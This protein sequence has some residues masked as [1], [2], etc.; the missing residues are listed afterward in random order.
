MACTNTKTFT[1]LWTIFWGPTKCRRRVVCLY[2]RHRPR[3]L[4]SIAYKQNDDWIPTSATMFFVVKLSLYMLRPMMA[5][6]RGDQHLKG[7]V[8]FR[9]WPLLAKTCKGLILLLK[10][11]LHL[12]EF[13]PNFSYKSCMYF[14]IVMHHT[15]FK[16]KSLDWVPWTNISC[17]PWPL[18]YMFWTSV[19]SVPL[20]TWSRR[21]FQT[22]HN[23]GPYKLISGMLLQQSYY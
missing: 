19:V 18:Q 1:A 13:N 2:D 8:A 6:I 5:I 20:E 7:L 14:H 16:N 21:F 23:A 17:K 12:M 22:N 15:T 11:L 4:H 10:T 3:L 9:W